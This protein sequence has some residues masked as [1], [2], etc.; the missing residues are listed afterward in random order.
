VR[1]LSALAGRL[2]VAAAIAGGLAS[3][4][5]CAA[6]RPANLP[7]PGLIALSCRQSAGQQGPDPDAVEVDGVASAALHGDTNAY[8]ELP[9]WRSRDGH[10]YL[11]W[12]AYLAVAATAR[13]YRLVSVASPR[14]ARLYYAS[15]TQ[16]GRE[17]GLPVIAP[18]P[19]S[20]RLSACGKKFA[21]YTGGIL[22]TRPGCV[23]LSVSGRRGRAYRVV[24]PVLV[25]RC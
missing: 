17:S 16:W 15:T 20:V 11:V 5:A 21:G 19:R 23:T 24:V 12:K 6:G 8:D 7:A 3:P 10:H 1:I 25:V 13:P 14:S 18:P 22:V 9:T 4:L 2:A